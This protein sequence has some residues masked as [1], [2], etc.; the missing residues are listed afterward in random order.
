MFLHK[1][2]IRIIT[3]FHYGESSLLFFKFT[4][5]NT[6]PQWNRAEKNPAEAGLVVYF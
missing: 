3:D 2:S 5:V 4:R 6:T 1:N